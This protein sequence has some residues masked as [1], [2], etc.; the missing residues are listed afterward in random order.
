MEKSERNLREMQARI[1]ELERQ[2]ERA[3]IQRQAF[4]KVRDS[5]WDMRTSDAYRQLIQAIWQALTTLGVSFRYC[6]INLIDPNACP[7]IV[8]YNMTD[9]ESELEIHEYAD[10]TDKPLIEIWR[11]QQ[12]V[13][14]PDL[15]KEDIYNEASM[16]R[17]G[18][19]SIVD[20]PFSH[21]TLAIS[22]E[23][24]DAFSHDDLEAFQYLA[25]ALTGGFRRLQDLRD[26]EERNRDLEREV[27][28][29][30][31]AESTIAVSL[32]VQR[33]RNESLRIERSEDWHSVVAACHREIKS[34]IDC[35]GFSINFV[36]LAEDA[37]YNYV[38]GVDGA[39]S[40]RDTMVGI[41]LS[42]RETIEQNAAVY[43]R[44]AEEIKRKG[45]QLNPARHS[46]V[47]V[48]FNGGT[49][50]I[51]SKREDAFSAKDIAVLFEFGRVISEAARRL[52][53][54]QLLDSRER[55]L[56]QAQTM[57]AIGQLTAG[58]AHNFNNMLQGIMGN[59][60]LATQE[61]VSAPQRDMLESADLAAR[62]AAAMVR[63]LL[64]F[65][66]PGSQR[67][68][69]SIDPSA[70]LA[71]VVEMG[72]RTFDRGIELT[73]AVE[74]DLPAIEMDGGQFEQIALNV[75]I[76][77]RDAVEDLQE[78][79]PHI[80][81]AMNE[82]IDADTQRA[83]LRIRTKDNGVGMSEKTSARIFEPFF[84]TKAVDK[85]TGLG[86]S[87]VYSIVQKQGGRIDC[88][89][90][91]GAGTTFSVYLPLSGDPSRPVATIDREALVGG[92]VLVIDDEESVRHSTMNIL[93]YYGYEVRVASDGIEGLELFR[94][95]RPDLVLLDLSMP[96]MSGR[97]VLKEMRQIDPHIK[98]LLFTGYA[99]DQEE[100]GNS[101]GVVHKPFMAVD[102][103]AAIT[104]AMQAT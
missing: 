36:D 13:Y 101:V 51:S 59:I 100:F 28:E 38:V 83:Y 63:Q 79:T 102:L 98:V 5:I 22:S 43:R 60:F 64:T 10:G 71:D 30:R 45:D 17:K 61:A 73:L 16:L 23:Q 15:Q 1:E 91:L 44:N 66:H 47:D 75:L 25:G 8:I 69:E 18:I 42:L 3:G 77:A 54:V 99:T 62:R 85:G 80:H 46:I 74:A 31:Q 48:P 104:Q 49:V 29:R 52:R 33:V 19:H 76:N 55:Q 12:L 84:T 26:L 40:K 70:R 53:D 9:V 93:Q 57:E 81:V 67:R 95:E 50:A 4:A 86:L 7:A 82:Y 88:E 6:G 96:R 87:T 37:F 94:Q 14:R 2:V 90:R 21:G 39:V 72:R 34:L 65:A 92:A 78:R 24:V 35:D 68:V 41:P 32:A 97:E 27:N 103:I 56:R 89:S 20:I 11:R 58:I